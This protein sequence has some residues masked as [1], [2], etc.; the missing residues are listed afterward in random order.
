MPNT[1]A[2]ARERLIR[3]LAM[4]RNVRATIG[5][6]TNLYSR[7]GAVQRELDTVLRDAEYVPDLPVILT[8]VGPLSGTDYAPLLRACAPK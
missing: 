1:K 5:D 7:L 3:A 4:L 8:P 2:N 6:T